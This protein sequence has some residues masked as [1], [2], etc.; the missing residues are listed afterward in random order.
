MV[1]AGMPPMEAIQSATMETA[2]LL[3]IQDT[4]GSVEKGKLAD[5]VAVKGDPL[6][7]ISV[8]KDVVFVMKAGTIYKR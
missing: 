1:A 2:R 6:Q 3:K 5:I 8:M 4:L 7:N